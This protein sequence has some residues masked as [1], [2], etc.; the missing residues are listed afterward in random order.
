MTGK[1][2]RA[3]A[4]VYLLLL[5]VFSSAKADEN[6]YLY[7][8]S[9]TSEVDLKLYLSDGT[10]A[11]LQGEPYFRQNIQRGPAPNPFPSIAVSERS[12]EYLGASNA[13]IDGIVF[14]NHGN[15]YVAQRKAVVLWAIRIPDAA[16]RS[17]SEFGRDMTL[18]LFVD[19]NQDMVWKE[20]E[21]MTRATLNLQQYLPTTSDNI[22]VYYLT[23]FTVPDVTQLLQSNKNFDDK[24]KDVRHMWAR[25]VLAYDDPDM[26]PDGAQLFGEYEDYLLSYLVRAQEISEGDD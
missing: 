1:R 7:D 26:S 6:V 13:I 2:W 5:T 14:V 19:W 8:P 18:S 24:D 11:P 22:I 23:T 3:S 16:A 25:G 21:R 9:V 15:H 20:G 4:L 10:V 17:A 12:F